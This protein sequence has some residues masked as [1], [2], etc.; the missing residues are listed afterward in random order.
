MCRA[1]GD[2]RP[3]THPS[4]WHCRVIRACVLIQCG[5]IQGGW[6]DCKYNFFCKFTKNHTAWT[7]YLTLKGWEING[8]RL[9]RLVLGKKGGLFFKTKWDPIIS[10]MFLFHCLP[11][12]VA[13]ILTRYTIKPSLVRED[14]NVI[15]TSISGGWWHIYYI[16]WFITVQLYAV[17]GREATLSRGLQPTP[18][19][20]Y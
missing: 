12:P 15:Q 16:R 3:N 1:R 2:H 6:K 8:E 20:R 4:Y 13:C 5:F 17:M 7:N 11:L 10:P 18:T 9:G 14:L 19:Q